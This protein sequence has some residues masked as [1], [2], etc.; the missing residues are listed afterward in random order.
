[1]RLRNLLDSM[2]HFQTGA[3]RSM[4]ARRNPTENTSKVSLPIATERRVVLGGLVMGIMI[5]IGLTVSQTAQANLPTTESWSVIPSSLAYDRAIFDSGAAIGLDRA[6]IP[7]SGTTDA[8]DGAEIEARAVRFDDA[9]DVPTGAATPWTPVGVAAGGTWQ[10]NLAVPRSTGTW[11]RAEVRVKG[12]TAPAALLPQRFEA[13]HVWAMYE[14][15]NWAQVFE[16]TETLPAA[17]VTDP[18]AVQVFKAN[19]TTGVASRS[20]ITTATP[21]APGVVALAN[22][23]AAERPGEKL[24]IAAHVMSGTSPQEMI[25]E[26]QVNPRKWDHEV[27]ITDL[28]TQCGQQVGVVWNMGWISWNSTPSNPAEMLPIFVGKEITGAA[29]A[30]GATTAAGYVLSH[31][32]REFYDFWNGTT[33]YTRA[34]FCGAHGKGVTVSKTNWL[35]GADDDHE[36]LNAKWRQVAADTAN[37]PEMLVC[38]A[39]NDGALRGEDDGAG[40]WQDTIHHHGH[41]DWGR[42]RLARIGMMNAL[43]AVGLASWP[44]AEFNRVHWATDGSHAD[45]W[46]DGYN[47]TTERNRTGGASVYVRGWSLDGQILTTE[48]QIVADAGGSGFAGV[49]ITP[50]AGYGPFTYASAIDYGRGE[51]PGFQTYPGDYQND[52]VLDLA[53]IDVGAAGM[54]ALPVRTRSAGELAN[55]LPA[56]AMFTVTSTAGPHFADPNTIGSNSGLLTMRAKMRWTGGG[57]TGLFTISSANMEITR[58]SD[59]SLRLVG[60]KDSGGTGLLT[61]QTLAGTAPTGNVVDIVVTM[62]LGAQVFRVFVDGVLTDDKALNA[63]TG[64]F[65]SGRNIVFFTSAGRPNADVEILEVWKAYAADGNT[66]ALGTPYKRIT[67]TT[68]GGPVEAPSLPAWR[69]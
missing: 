27:A 43:Q 63:G 54:P 60:L 62:N 28:I 2:G 61:T 23:F 36:K 30:P 29:V 31:D 46:M 33:G 49:R 34:A 8:P 13:G 5:A 52:Y 35:T 25:A 20:F 40:G 26:P 22:A 14:Q 24:A 39:T 10:G 59:G 3:V 12:A 11:S 48:A 17:A 57:G 15:S 32:L 66:A 38:A 9:T 68:A 65:A 56:P 6:D 55:T 44:T 47:V 1:M 41:V 67:G 37:F 45:F 51:L 18:E 4:I 53:V 16:S 69:K 64:Q 42:N 21:M 19:R 50:P 7:L 58:L